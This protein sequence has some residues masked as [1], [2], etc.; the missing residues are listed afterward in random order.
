[1]IIFDCM[2]NDW[3]VIYSSNQLYE[4]EMAKSILLENNIESFIVN[5]QDSLYL[6]GEIELYVRMDDI[7]KAKLIISEIS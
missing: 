5:K 1:M 7:M 3:S 2:D 6:I 4:I